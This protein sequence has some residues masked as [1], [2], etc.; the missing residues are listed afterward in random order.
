MEIKI[1][2]LLDEIKMAAQAIL[3]FTAGN[4][5]T[6]LTI[7]FTLYELALNKEI[8]D[9]LREE[10]RETFEKHGDFTYEAI[11]EM[12]YIDMVFNGK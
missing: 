9:R 4:D 12:T 10:I 2:L 5:T 6:S 1:I 3:F 7:T 8:Q 11:Q